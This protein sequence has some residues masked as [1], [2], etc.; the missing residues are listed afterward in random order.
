MARR[1]RGAAKGFPTWLNLIRGISSEGFGRI[2]YYT[3]VREL[4]DT[5]RSVAAY[6]AA[7]TQELPAFYKQ[8]VQRDLG[9]LW[10]YLPEG[11][12]YHDAAAYLN[13]Q[14]SQLEARLTV[15]R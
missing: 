11:A 3:K 8:R 6:F 10:N 4:L 9:P 7:E 12:L 2:K 15:R 13:K 14:T 5:D 1:A